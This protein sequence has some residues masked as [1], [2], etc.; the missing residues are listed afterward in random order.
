M[1]MSGRTVEQIA[2]AGIIKGLY[3]GACHD[4]EHVFLAVE[5]KWRFDLEA[6]DHPMIGEYCIRLAEGLTKR[7]QSGIQRLTTKVPARPESHVRT[8]NRAGKS[9]AITRQIEPVPADIRTPIK[10]SVRHVLNGKDAQ[11]VLVIH[12]LERTDSFGFIVSWV[13]SLRPCLHKS[14]AIKA[15]PGR[16]IQDLPKRIFFVILMLA[17][18]KA[19]QTNG[20][21]LAGSIRSSPQERWGELTQG[22][23]RTGALQQGPAGVVFHG[24]NEWFIWGI[25]RPSG[26]DF[27]FG[28]EWAGDRIR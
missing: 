21:F 14:H 20:R 3:A 10:G 24:H 26:R 18:F 15:L 9:C 17:R 22:A 19:I 2:M 16:E 27:P 12:P 23:G 8:T 7:I 4:S 6:C 11:P 28:V 5:H 25:F 1:G 13:E